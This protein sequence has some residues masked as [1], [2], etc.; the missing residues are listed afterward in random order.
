M[1][2]PGRKWELASMPGHELS[3]GG[4]KCCTAIWSATGWLG[5]PSAFYKGGFRCP[6]ASLMLSTH[7][8]VHAPLAEHMPLLLS[9]PAVMSLSLNTHTHSCA[10]LHYPRLQA[11]SVSFCGYLYAHTYA[12]PSTVLQTC[13]RTHAGQCSP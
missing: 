2:L 12:K 13:I 4:R 5:L 6:P 1:V 8:Y 7:I 11:C 10:C 3:I 9:R